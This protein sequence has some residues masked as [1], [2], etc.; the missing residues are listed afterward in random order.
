VF[1]RGG[2]ILP[3][4]VLFA[5]LFLLSIILVGCIN[6]SKNT[7]TSEPAALEAEKGIHERDAQRERIR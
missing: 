5:S 3:P 7:E 4:F 1:L 2:G 6:K